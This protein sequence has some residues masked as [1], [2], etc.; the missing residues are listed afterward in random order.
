MRKGKKCSKKCICKRHKGGMSRRRKGGFGI[1][2]AALP[3]GLL[4]AQKSTQRNSP[5]PKKHKSK[6]S[7][8]RR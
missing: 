8:S 2:A 7:R 4:A 1:L 5:H 6:Y 3:L